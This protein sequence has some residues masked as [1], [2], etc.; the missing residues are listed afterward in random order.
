[1][2]GGQAFYQVKDSSAMST[3]SRDNQ[4]R[5]HFMSIE[6]TREAMTA[7]LQTLVERG[8]YGIYFAADVTFTMMG[9]GQ[10]VSGQSEVEQFIRYFHEQAFDAEPIV[11]NVVVADGQAALEAD[12][13]GN[14]TGEFLGVAA[15]GRHVN[16]PYA[17]LYDLAGDKITALRAYLPMDVLMQQLGV[18]PAPA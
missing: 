5:R 10:V 6:H 9:A 16:V 1:M 17:V 8:T 11:K 12:F 14:H 3:I 2:Y 15:T 18:T 13:V 4:K 7:Y